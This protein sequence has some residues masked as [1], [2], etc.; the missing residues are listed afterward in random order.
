MG[1]YSTGTGARHGGHRW[2]GVGVAGQTPNLNDPQQR[3]GPQAV[4]ALAVDA[5]KLADLQIQLLTLD[6]R[7]TWAGAWR[8]LLA[9]AFSTAAVIAALPVAMFG[10][11]EFLRQAASLSIET[12]LL[13]VSGIVLAAAGGLAVWSARQ[14]AVA[15]QPLRRSTDE[16]R[17]NLEWMRS[18][19]YEESGETTPRKQ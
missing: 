11:S 14:L 7:E 17:S 1:A 16:L 5:L 10:I 9:L 4:L 18:V 8:S 6:V 13:L 12:A 3:H 15:L 19:L 2:S